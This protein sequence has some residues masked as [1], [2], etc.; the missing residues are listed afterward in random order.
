[1]AEE[2]PEEG[3]VAAAGPPA[4]VA[5]AGGP[6]VAKEAV[7]AEVVAVA[8]EPAEVEVGAAAVAGASEP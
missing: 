5:V 3:R 2:Q 8:G 7:A 1:V 6:A 4:V